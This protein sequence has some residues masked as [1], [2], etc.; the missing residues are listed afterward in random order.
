MYS[1]HYKIIKFIGF[2]P[3][4]YV[5]NLSDASSSMVFSEFV[6]VFVLLI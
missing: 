3:I 5:I 6:F 1:S 2:E 4:C